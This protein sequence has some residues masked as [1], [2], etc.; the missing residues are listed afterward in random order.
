M[1]QIKKKFME[2]IRDEE[3]ASGIEYAL[4][5]AMVAV[6]LVTFITPIRTAVKDIFTSI[7]TALTTGS[8]SS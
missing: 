7:Q 8:S 1:T 3:G 2:F 5:A 6:V 4:I